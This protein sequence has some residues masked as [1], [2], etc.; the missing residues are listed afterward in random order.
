MLCR[1][2]TDGVFQLESGG[3]RA[4]VKD[5][6]PNCFE[7]IN[8]L[9]ALY[10]PGP[11]N[12]GMATE[13]VNR[14]HGRSRID[15][16]DPK[17]EPILKDTYGTIVYQ[18][19]IMQVAQ[20]LGGYTLGQA[21]LLRRAMGK[22]KQEEMDKQRDMFVSGCLKGN[23]GEDKANKLFDTM[24]EF[25]AYCFNRSHSA[26]YAFVAYQ[27]AYLK[28]HYPVEYLSALLSSVSNDLDKIQQYMV[29]A[30]TMGI[31]ILPPDINHSDATFTPDGQA[32]RFGLASI[33]NVGEGIVESIAQAR[34]AG[35]NFTSME[36]FCRRVDLK[37][38][39]RRTMEALISVGAFESFGLSRQ[40]LMENIETIYSYAQRHA[41]RKVTGQTSLFAF[42]AAENGQDDQAAFG[43][44]IAWRGPE[45]EYD[46]GTTQRMEKELLGFYVTSHPLDRVQETL[47]LMATHE[48]GQ[49]KGLSD[50]TTIQV[51]GLITNVTHRLTRK[52][53]PM[54]IGQLEDLSGRAE[55]VAFSEAL[56]T[57]G[58][59]LAAGQ[60]VVL[61]VTFSIR[62]DDSYSLVVESAKLVDD[63]TILDLY[64]NRPP[65]FEEVDMIRNVLGKLRG[66]DPVIINWPGDDTKLVVGKQFWVNSEKAEAV[67]NQQMADQLPVT[68]KR[69]SA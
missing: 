35:G 62:G 13:F 38:L 17:L 33:K 25:A 21:D 56:E 54:L 50:G 31:A 57:Y 49:L 15:Y 66:E 63:V 67:F 29:T 65:R 42:A 69:R 28:A 39:N 19:Q 2:D 1:A 16:P 7:D 5:L 41:E 22:K 60:T 68:A 40:Q 11:L 24:A 36:D 4:L 3:M 14:K 48:L 23:L 59:E 53:K 6:K 20:T 45:A 51:A 9:V 43:E 55:F 52:N 30:R 10:R 58:D 26:A 61:E 8:A 64:F 18:E 27:T 37:A 32:I 12:S 44:Q 47:P 34:Q 46:E